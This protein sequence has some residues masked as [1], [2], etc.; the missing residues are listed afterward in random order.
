[1]KTDIVIRHTANAGVLISIG[2]NSL[3]VDLFSRDLEGL[4]QDTPEKLKSELLDEIERGHIG[5]LLFTHGHGD[6]FCLE[7]V[8]EALKRNPDLIVVSTNEVIGLLKATTPFGKQLYAI[9][10][11]EKGNV[12]V[13]FSNGSLE[14][15]N[16]KHMG[17][18]YAEVQNLV[19]MLEAEGRQIVI[20]GDAWP[21]PELFAR[22]GEWSSK[23]DVLIAPFPLIGLPSSR[24]ML[25]KYLRPAH[26]FA[27]HL[28]RPEMDDQ[29]WVA[30]AKAVCNRAEDGLPMPVFGQ[31]LGKEYHFI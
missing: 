3:G 5:A 31:I 10:S 1:M 29:N 18:A 17:E 12:K 9:S 6:H 23:P 21:E 14:L 2:R 13:Y 19:F 7:D 24:R 8:A 11:G 27:L 22:I 15:F 25:G 20:P 26:I 28:P 4:Y 16:S 30:S